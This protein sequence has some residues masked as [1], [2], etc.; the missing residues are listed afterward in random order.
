MR[1]NIV[2]SIL[3]IALIAV[4]AACSSQTASQG[5]GG[6]EH[7][8]DAGAGEHGGDGHSHDGAGGEAQALQ[9]IFS[10]PSGTPKP[11]ADTELSIRIQ[12]DSGTSVNDY[13]ISHEKLMH[14]IIVSRDFSFFN[15]IHPEFRGNGT[16]T[17][18]TQFPA[19]GDYKIFADFV[20][21]GGSAATISKWVEVGGGKAD[22]TAIVPDGSLVKTVDGKEVELSID[23]LKANADATLTFTIRDEATKEGIDNLEPYLGAVGH[24]VVLSED[25]EHYLHVHPMDEK[26]SGPDAV[27]MTS[28]PHAGIFKI[29]GQFQHEGEVFTVPFVVDVP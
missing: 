4:L 17:V 7:G 10:F 5:D 15:H 25:A 20:P 16:F 14:I 24:V 18:S 2:I 29:W 13:D 1:R 8:H 27:F 19:G 3:S 6:H 9:A 28:F 22:E 26:T 21:K 23:N 11:G 12:D